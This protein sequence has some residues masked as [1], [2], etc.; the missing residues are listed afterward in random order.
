DSG[1][2]ITVTA[3]VCKP[4]REL[5]RA[6]AVLRLPQPML[7]KMD[8]VGRDGCRCRS[9]AISQSDRRRA[10]SGG[11]H[12]MTVLSVVAVAPPQ[13]AARRGARAA[14]ERA[15]A[16]AAELEGPRNHCA[17]SMRFAAAGAEAQRRVSSFEALHDHELSLAKA[18]G[19]DEDERHSG[20]AA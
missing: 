4:R 19:R 5:T 8:R 2:R 12:A 1:S 7:A 17:V 15:D 13:S 16:I 18:G 20:Q 6:S 3:R 9:E 14:A 11:G 10:E